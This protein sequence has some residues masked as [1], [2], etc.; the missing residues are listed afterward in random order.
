MLSSPDASARVVGSLSREHPGGG[1]AVLGGA[2]AHRMRKL[3]KAREILRRL[4]DGIADLEE[5]VG[6]E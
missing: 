3:A 2:R 5:L 1:T 4:Q 6:R